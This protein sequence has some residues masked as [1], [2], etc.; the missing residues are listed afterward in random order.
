MAKLEWDVAGHRDFE[1]GVDRGV[2]F[3][4]EDGAYDKGV[5]WSGLI[6]VSENPSGADL[7]E[8][9]ADNILYAAFRNAEKFGATVEAYMHPDEFYA[10]NGEVEATDGMYIGQQPR[11]PFGLAYRTGVMNDAEVDGNDYKIHLV[12]NATVNPSGKTYQTRSD[13]PDPNTMSWEIVTV[14]VEMEG[15]K[16]VSHIVIDSRKAGKTTLSQIEGAIYGDD[17]NDPE[18]PTPTELLGLIVHPDLDIIDGEIGRVYAFSIVDKNVSPKLIGIDPS[19]INTPKGYRWVYNTSDSAQ[20]RYA[21]GPDA[22]TPVAGI[23]EIELEPGETT[24]SLSGEKAYM[25]IYMVGDDDKA[26]K[27]DTLTVY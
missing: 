12:Y 16:P 7:T 5:A 22:G 26:V 8:M 27:Y 23:K 17:E 21:E 6:S 4:I 19:Y 11:Q 1:M 15:R 25:H 18:L 10:C 24:V 20:P 14:P 2:L 3:P 13:N 9:W